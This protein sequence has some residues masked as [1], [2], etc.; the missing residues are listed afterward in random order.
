MKVMQVLS[1]EGRRVTE[2]ELDF[3]ELT[4]L[5]IGTLRAIGSGRFDLD[6]ASDRMM[7]V[8]YELQQL[9]L[10]TQ[11]YEL[12]STGE[13]AIH[14]AEKL[15]G[16]AERRRAASKVAVEQE[17]DL[18]SVDV[19]DYDDDDY[20]EYEGNDFTEFSGFATQNN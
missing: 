15:G 9:N 3:N 19:D 6:E 12:T 8:T 5:Q 13:K 18:V 1:E 20:G 14:L 11:D 7:D 16:S 4:S 2:I 10:V 17:D